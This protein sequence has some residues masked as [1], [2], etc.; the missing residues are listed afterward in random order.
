MEPQASAIINCWTSPPELPHGAVTIA[1]VAA[2]QHMVTSNYR[3]PAVGAMIS[4]QPV[5]RLLSCNSLWQQSAHGSNKLMKGYGQTFCIALKTYVLQ[6]AVRQQFKGQ[7][8]LLY[9]H[10]DMPLAA[11]SSHRDSC[12][13]SGWCESTQERT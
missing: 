8:A 12:C 4:R 11:S 6:R 3:A 5:R 1:V 10:N 2:G 13:V 7:G 9:D